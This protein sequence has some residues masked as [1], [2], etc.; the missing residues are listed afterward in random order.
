M[1][2]ERTAADRMTRTAPSEPE[3][4]RHARER[5]DAVFKPKP[6]AA[7][8]DAGGKAV[9]AATEQHPVRAPR[10]LAASQPQLEPASE[11]RV[12]AEPA[13]PASKPKAPEIP[14]SEYRRIRTLAFY[15]MAIKQV[16]EVYGVSKSEIERI[17]RR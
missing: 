9:A 12:Q 15:G 6:A 13:A 11:P 7:I 4:A 5:A 17:I 2:I 14:S 1:P 3:Q 16:A 8:D 10:I